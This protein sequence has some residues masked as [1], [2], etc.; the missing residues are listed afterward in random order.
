MSGNGILVLVRHGESTANASQHFTGLLD[1]DL[2]PLGLRQ[3]RIAARLL[4]GESLVPEVVFTSPLTRARRTA[5][6]IAEDRGIGDAPLNPC[7][8]LEERDYGCLSGMAKNEVR[9]RFGPEMFFT[10]RR[11]VLGK[12]PPAPPEQVSNWNIVSTRPPGMPAPGEGESLQDVI[13]R[14]RPCWDQDL[15]PLLHA[16]RCVLVVAHGN[17][18]RALCSIIDD[19]SAAEVESLNLPPGQ[20]LRYDVT[21]DGRLFPRGGRY[22]DDRS[23]RTAAAK[24]AREGGT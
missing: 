9:A 14:V 7:W 20:P 3:A 5:D 13:D 4:E 18:L 17:S 6:M 1:V 19:L 10:W 2:T 15:L 11:T 12:P 8:R 21:P 22:L 23:A 16:G 24:I